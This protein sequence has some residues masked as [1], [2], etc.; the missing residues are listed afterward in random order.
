MDKILSLLRRALQA[1]QTKPAPIQEQPQQPKPMRRP[2]VYSFAAAAAS[3]DKAIEPYSYEIKPPELLP[4]VIPKNVAK[5]AVAMDSYAYSQAATMYPGGGFPGYPYL[6]QL[7]TRGEYRSFAS[8]LS[9]ELT[10]K[11]VEFYGTSD[12]DDD[13]VTADKIKKIEKAFEEFDVQKVIQMAAMHECFFGRGQVFIDIRGHDRAV[14]LVLSPK[15]VAKGSL[16]GVSAVEPIWVTPSAYNTLD[17]AAP[18]FYKPHQWFMLGQEV[19]ASRLQMIITRPMPDLLKPAFNF[20]GMSLSQIAEPYVDNWLRTRQSVSDLIA[21]FS[22]TALKTNMSD[23]LAG[24]DEGNSL[25]ARVNLFLATRSNLGVMALDKDK[26]E[27]VQI[28]TPLSGLHELQAQSQEHMCSI[29]RIP[30]II[31]T[32]ISPSGLNASSEGEIRV[33]Y[34]WIAA[35]QNAYYLPVVKVILQV[36]QLHLFGEIDPNICVKFVSLYEMTPKEEAEIREIDSRVDTNYINAGVISQEEVRV[37]LAHSEISGYHG[38][39]AEDVPEPPKAD[40]PPENDPMQNDQFAQDEWNESDHPRDKNGEFGS[41]SGGSVKKKPKLTPN[42]KSALSSY[43]GDDFLKL[44]T[45]LRNGETV[46]AEQ[47]KRIDSAIS[48]GE[49]PAE[50]VLY[51]GM[52]R[53]AAK[54]LFPQGQID[55]G[56]QITDAAFMSTSESKSIAGMWGAGGVVLQIEAQEG[57]KGLSMQG[58]SSNP[59]EKEVLLPRNAKMIVQG[60]VPPKSIGEPVVV[61][62]SYE[63]A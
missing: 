52:T 34:D 16:K 55:K 42:E 60:V 51:R 59:N 26:E 5:P 8:T 7:A 37:K 58:I 39:D 11:W 33:F 25:K 1:F 32:G 17:P 44:N 3:I 30:A 29:S 12:D 27:L 24:L 54:Q 22:I 43:S 40:T 23:M 9:T 10:R 49:L 50:T 48:K 21:N 57:A 47:V 61:R 62:V 38:L 6:S 36:M 28:N 2:A 46:D 15:T 20:S 4:G 31:L 35:T 19:H 14:P 18:D 45:A 63:S 41:G 56:T 13:E 53:E